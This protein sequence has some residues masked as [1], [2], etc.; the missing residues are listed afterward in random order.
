MNLPPIIIDTRE[1]KGY[2]FYGGDVIRKK[3]DTGDYSIEG[4]ED[5]FVTERKSLD[6]YLRSISHDRDR[7]KRE[8][9]RGSDMEEFTVII[10]ADEDYVRSGDYRREVAPMSAINTAEAWGN[11]HDVEFI[12]AGTR[13]KAK[14]KTVDKLEEWYEDYS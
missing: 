1:Q 7:F 2:S 10:E 5:V 14:A 11:R 9:K 13:S 12:W 3:L 4:Y 6:D 8:V